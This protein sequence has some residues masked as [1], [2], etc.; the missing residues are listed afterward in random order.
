VNGRLF[1][2]ARGNAFARNHEDVVYTAPAPNRYTSAEVK[3]GGSIARAER[4]LTRP[5]G[6]RTIVQCHPR[7]THC[8]AYSPASLAGAGFFM[9]TDEPR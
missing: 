1:S 3:G 2:S 9:A 6:Q 4:A 5:A 8:N 7:M